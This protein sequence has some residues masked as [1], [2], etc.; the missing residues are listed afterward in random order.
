MCKKRIWKS[1]L[2]KLPPAATIRL[3]DD[4][5]V[6]VGAG[7]ASW[8]AVDRWTLDLEIGDPKGRQFSE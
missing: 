5:R 2:K 7:R 6:V 1:T 3:I 8:S 4:E